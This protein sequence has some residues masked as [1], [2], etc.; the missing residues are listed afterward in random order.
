MSR[1]AL[2]E[3]MS[4]TVLSPTS[5]ENSK[6]FLRWAGSKKKLVPTLLR[7]MNIDFNKYIEPFVGSAQLFFAYKPTAAVLSDTN[8]SLIECYVAVKENASLVF[9]FLASFPVGKEEYYK[10]RAADT[11]NWCTEKKAA[12]FMYLNTYCFNGLY[13]TNKSGAFNVPYSDGIPNLITYDRLLR[14]SSDLQA[15]TFCVGDFENIVSSHCVPGDFVYLDPPYAVRNK[16]MFIQ[17]GPDTFRLSD[18]V[19]LKECI[20]RIDKMKATFLLSYAHCDEA[21]AIAEH[22]HYKVVTT[23]RNISGFAKHRKSENEILI[24]NLPFNE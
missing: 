11:C 9:E 2:F 24:S 3:Q 21:L 1:F 20:T 17:Y 14:I 4:P 16:D 7:S 5:R 19:R 6:S 13:R 10:I 12:R 8:E 18:L 22:W 23:V 15:A